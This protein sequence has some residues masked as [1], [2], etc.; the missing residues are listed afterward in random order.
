ME[1]PGEHL[2]A[3]LLHMGMDQATLSVR[4]DVSRQTVN[5][6]INGRQ[7]ISRSIARKLGAI[8]GRDEDYWL[9]SSFAASRR[10]APVPQRKTPP[11]PQKITPPEPWRGQDSKPPTGFHQFLSVAA[12]ELAADLRRNRKVAKVT[13]WSDLRRY[14]LRKYGDQ[15]KLVEARAL[16]KGY[17]KAIS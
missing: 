17:L 5:N 11:E 8:T 16:W 15:E 4:L 1:T 9:R 3:E 7:E 13:S 6:I 14:I 2:R 10:A 12:G